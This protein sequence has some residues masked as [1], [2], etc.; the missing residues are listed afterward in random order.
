[1]NVPSGDIKQDQGDTNQTFLQSWN[2]AAQT[3]KTISDFKVTGVKLKVAQHRDPPRAQNLIVRIYG[4]DGDGY[5]DMNSLLA[6]GSYPY[7]S[8]PPLG[9]PDFVTVS[10]SC[11]LV[12]DTTY[13]IV[14]Y[15][16]Y[17]DYL[18]AGRWIAYTVTDIYADGRAFYGYNIR[19]LPDPTEWSIHGIAIDFAFIV[20]GESF[21]DIAKALG[22]EWGETTDYGEEWI[23]WGE[24]TTGDYSHKITG[25]LPG[26][27]YHFRAKACV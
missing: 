20:L 18:D 1:L 17:L 4:T 5:P 10:L 3:F 7:D 11:D 15:L 14:A 27:T 21:S 25:L 2:A 26:T 22:F 9:S 19:D 16:S 6:E 24:F 12:G 23:E 8:L 13:A